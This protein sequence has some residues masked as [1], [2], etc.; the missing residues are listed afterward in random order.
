MIVLFK[1]YFQKRSADENVAANMTQY[2]LQHRY[3]DV[4][5]NDFAIPFWRDNIEFDSIITDRK[6][7]YRHNTDFINNVFILA[8]YGIRE[9]TERVGT[10]KENYTVKEEHLSTHIPAKIE[11]GISNIYTD[12]LMF[13]AK[14]LTLGGRLVC[15][16]PVFR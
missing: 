7:V 4:L 13:S 2:N 1:I 9:A 3:L 8:P 6:K 15:W 16:F 12:L 14:H 5:V 11:Y 10:T